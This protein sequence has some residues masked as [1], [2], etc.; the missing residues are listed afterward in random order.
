MASNCRRG[1]ASRTDVL[2]RH[3][4]P[5]YRPALLLALLPALRH[6]Q[7]PAAFLRARAD[8][9]SPYFDGPAGF[10]VTLEPLPAY[11]HTYGGDADA[12]ARL[13]YHFTTRSPALDQSAQYAAGTAAEYEAWRRRQAASALWIEDGCVHDRRWGWSEA[14]RVLDPA[15]AALMTEAWRI[16]PWKRV[17]ADSCGTAAA[18]ARME[19]R[20]WLMRESGSV[21]ALPLRAGG[22]AGF[23]AAPSLLQIRDAI[24]LPFKAA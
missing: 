9:F 24:G 20:G 16:V 22:G 6:L 3:H 4:R 19:S 8:R 1:R 23:R 14:D 12:Q 17:A 13:G 2:A 21:L 18:A 10:G 7:P 5:H 15:E 11:R